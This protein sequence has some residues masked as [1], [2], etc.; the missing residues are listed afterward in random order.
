M[1]NTLKL[2]ALLIENGYT[3]STIS[4][5]LG[6][7]QQ[8]FCMKINNKRE[9][10]M[11]EIAKLIEIL[12]ISDSDIMTIFYCRFC[13]MKNLQTKSAQVGTI[14]YRGKNTDK[15]LNS[16]ALVCDSRV[17]NRQELL[18]KATNM[19]IAD[20]QNYIINLET[21]KGANSGSKAIKN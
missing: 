19:L 8:S 6:M 20:L 5:K 7:S 9:F 12:R 15:F 17:A 21:L 2:R 13:W 3:N 11:S 18:D 1:T 16:K 10:K 4:K 14:S